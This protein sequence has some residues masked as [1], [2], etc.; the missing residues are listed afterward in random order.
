MI[1]PVAVSEIQ[2]S[3]KLIKHPSQNIH[4]SDRFMLEIIIEII[5]IIY[6]DLV[7]NKEVGLNI[8]SFG[9]YPF[10][11]FLIQI[12]LVAKDL[13]KQWIIHYVKSFSWE[14]ILFKSLFSLSI[15]IK[16]HFWF[17]IPIII[18][19][20]STQASCKPWNFPI[21]IMFSSALINKL[22]NK[23]IALSSSIKFMSEIVLF[24]PKVAKQTT[25]CWQYYT[26][27]SS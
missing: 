12:M 14:N 6:I 24:N 10:L 25:S 27:S 7:G 2:Y 20:S 17:W 15:R 5:P 4:R 9:N 19:K 16:Y 23:N 1:V 13:F 8:K 18:S 26:V 21:H 22:R 11:F 3:V